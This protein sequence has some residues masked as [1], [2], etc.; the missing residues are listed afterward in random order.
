MNQ[1]IRST[2]FFLL[3]LAWAVL[4]GWAGPSLNDDPP[5]AE[6]AEELQRQGVA[7]DTASLIKALTT[8]SD[9]AVRWRAAEVLGLRRERSALQVLRVA[10]E[11]D[12]EEVV[13]IAAARSLATLGDNEGFGFLRSTM[14][15]PSSDLRSKMALA[16]TLANLG[17]PSG[18]IY[19]HSGATSP[20]LLLRQLSVSALVSLVPFRSATEQCDPV[21]D[22]EKLLRDA[23]AQVRIEVLYNVPSAIAHGASPD[24][25]QNIVEELMSLDADP[26]IRERARLTLLSLKESKRRE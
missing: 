8:H 18:C 22:L 12:T 4:Q 15:G 19:A 1:I 13:R 9:F 16:T 21:Q 25:L 11:K 26:T 14:N 2:L 24:K 17:D 10:V 6:L 3:I 7:G 23:E 5:W 20:D